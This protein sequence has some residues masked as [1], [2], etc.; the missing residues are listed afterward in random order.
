MLQQYNTIIPPLHTGHKNLK[1]MFFVFI[2]EKTHRYTPVKKL[3]YFS[4]CLYCFVVPSGK[5]IYIAFMTL[6]MRPPHFTFEILVSYFICIILLTFC[7]EPEELETNRQR[8]RRYFSIA[9]VIFS[10]LVS[11]IGKCYGTTR[12]F[13]VFFININTE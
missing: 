10:M 7:R 3:K 2:L 12:I 9:I 11:S 5:H 1:S 13:Y 4:G 6:I 8:F